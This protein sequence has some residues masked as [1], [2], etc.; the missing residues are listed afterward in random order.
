ML[1][2][3]R[4]LSRAFTLIEL[5]VVIAIIAILAA[6]L[7][8]AL[9][10]AREKSRRAACT[11]NLQQMSTALG[12]YVADYNGYYPSHCGYGVP[13]P[14]QQ[15]VGTGTQTV[16]MAGEY[17]DAAGMKVFTDLNYRA[18][19]ASSSHMGSHFLRN[20]A[21]GAF[22][23]PSARDFRANGQLRMGPYG[24][25]F[26]LVGGYLSDAK[27]FY[28]ASSADMINDRALIARRGNSPRD[29]VR[30]GGFDGRTLT[31]G[32]WAH[33]SSTNAS[34]TYGGGT[35][36]QA[37]VQGHYN[38][39][40]MP[41]TNAGA[42]E[43]PI[44]YTAPYRYVANEVWVPVFKTDK[45]LGG[46]ALASDTFSSG[47]RT[48]IS[49][50]SNLDDYFDNG[51]GNAPVACPAADKARSEGLM[52]F[53]AFA[54]RD[55]YNVLYGDGHTAWFADSEQ[56]LVYWWSYLAGLSC[57]GLEFHGPGIMSLRDK[58][59]SGWGQNYDQG[60]GARKIFHLMEVAAGIDV[61]AP[62]WPG[63]TGNEQ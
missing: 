50:P 51:P 7:L 36:V 30:A 16:W 55:G 6:M 2:N 56:R 9:A 26:L 15:Y 32:Q 40:L 23:S 62:R 29:W 22:L 20:L 46:R 61:N 45:Q 31:H 49:G 43:R 27:M 48:N 25:G 18:Y 14:N 35:L 53:G 17:A 44:C 60:K 57:G 8:P 39:Q 38:Y 13:V 52:G 24:L 19:D 1:R 28:C 59:F 47:I 33:V 3:W 54:H 37:V 41:V 5:L 34:G 12:S 11:G 58:S 4:R 21:V 42:A 63:Y 10:S